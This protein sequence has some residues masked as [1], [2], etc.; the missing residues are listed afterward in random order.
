MDSAP[1]AFNSAIQILLPEPTL[2]NSDAL[3][4][5]QM[6]EQG[7]GVQQP[8]S[9]SQTASRNG[10]QSAGLAQQH[11]AFAELDAVHVIGSHSASDVSFHQRQD[12]QSFTQQMMEALLLNNV[13]TVAPPVDHV[14]GQH[15]QQP[16]GPA[17]VCLTSSEF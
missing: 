2:Q 11:T 9:L 4:N 8:A 16:P 17:E 12:A 6:Q 7:P 3:N 13:Q 10:T 14:Q 5:L 1:D 15:T